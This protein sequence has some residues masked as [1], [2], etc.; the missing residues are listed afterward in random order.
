MGRFIDQ[1]L[2]RFDLP[3]E[4]AGSAARITL[5]GGREVCIE[6]HRGLLAYTQT[7]VSVSCG[8]LR[9]RIRGTGLLL[10]A[11]TSELL[12]VGGEIDG[13]DLERSDGRL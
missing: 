9:C 8:A 5:S 10:R 2:A 1:L 7:E 11:M 13:V 6:R 12:L 3:P 4:S